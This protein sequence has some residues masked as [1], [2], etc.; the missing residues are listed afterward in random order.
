MRLA[1]YGI[2]AELPAGW[3]GRIYRRPEGDP[4]LHAANFPL[5]VE[6]GDFASGALGAMGS[7]GVLVV[8]TEYSRDLAGTGLFAP[9]GLP[10]PLRPADPSPGALQRTR[11]GLSGV[12]RFFTLEGRAF[13]LYV[14]V[15]SMPSVESLVA[16]ANQVLHSFVIAPAGR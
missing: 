12:Q 4:T 16:Q 15:G 13:C 2:D 1:G 3:D 11:A 5:P 8:L 9:I 14:V 6:D 10:R 7:N